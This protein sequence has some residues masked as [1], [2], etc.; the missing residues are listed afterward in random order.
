MKKAKLLALETI[1][2]LITYQISGNPF[3]P[4]ILEED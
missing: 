1:K 4:Q 3:F 2:Q